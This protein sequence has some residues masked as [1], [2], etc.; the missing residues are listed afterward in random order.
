MATADSI[1]ADI[2]K[3]VSANWSDIVTDLSATPKKVSNFT[4]NVGLVEATDGS[5][6]YTVKLV[7]R[8]QALISQP[9]VNTAK[10]KIA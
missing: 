10:G 6:S 1:N 8:K 7:S 9:V 2:A 3:A 5:I 4:I